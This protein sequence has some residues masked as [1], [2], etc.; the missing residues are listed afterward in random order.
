MKFPVSVQI[1]IAPV[2]LLL[3]PSILPHQ[4]RIFSGLCE[5]VLLTARDENV[6]EI[7]MEKLEV[8]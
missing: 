5:E 7:K 8:G 2:D 4:L 6:K 3:L 1:N